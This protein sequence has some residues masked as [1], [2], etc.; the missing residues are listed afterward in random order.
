MT[1]TAAV[2]AVLLAV[3][4]A[5]PLAGCGEREAPSAAGGDAVARLGDAALTEAELARAVDGLPADL[6]SAAA[7]RA[8]VEAWVARELFVQEA[9]RAGL[10]ADPEVARRLEESA[11]AVLEDAARDRLLADAL[12]GDDVAAYYERHR[13]SLALRE[14]YVRL[15]H[16]RVPADR[17]EAA[18]QA[19]ADA[20]TTPDPDAAFATVARRFASDPDGAVAFAASF[21]PESRL[22]E[23]A[24]ALADGVAGLAPGGATAVIPDGPTAHVVHVVDRVAEGAVPPLAVIRAELAEQLR[25]SRRHDAEARL[26]ERLRAEA[27][28]RGDLVLP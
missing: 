20:L 12:A 10:D 24:P 27:V 5:A 23:V 25:A 15:R 1:R 19:L 21:A 14:P 22:R 8:A 2:P 26:L 13:A 9:R 3:L 7:R 17:A 6:D 18:E 4:L 28:A 16:L 11:R